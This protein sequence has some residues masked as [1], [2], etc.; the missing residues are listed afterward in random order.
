MLPAPLALQQR[1]CNIR[2]NSI[3]MASNMFYQESAPLG[4]PT[5][6]CQSIEHGHP[7]EA[8]ATDV[9]FWVKMCRGLKSNLV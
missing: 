2:Y 9:F 8:A 7:G 4:L 1:C 5:A 6:V 3:K